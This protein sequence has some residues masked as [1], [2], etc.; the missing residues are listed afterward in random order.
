MT[1]HWLRRQASFS[2]FLIIG[3][4]NLEGVE[5]NR[6]I[7]S[8]FVNSSSKQVAL[9]SHQTFARFVV[10]TLAGTGGL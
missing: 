2:Y 4:R 6:N 3:R 9:R 7:T 10:K 8:L 5:S 1:V